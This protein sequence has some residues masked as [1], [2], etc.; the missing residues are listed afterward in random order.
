M[1]K[2]SNST[3][4]RPTYYLLLAKIIKTKEFLNREKPDKIVESDQQRKTV[5]TIEA[6]VNRLIK[7]QK[8]KSQKKKKEDRTY[9]VSPIN[10]IST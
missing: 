1:S 3:R 10:S 7:I 5:K 4:P 9:N 6:R 2:L 8:K